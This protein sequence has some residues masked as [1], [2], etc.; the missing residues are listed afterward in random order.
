VIK[1]GDRVKFTE[2][3]GQE[4][5]GEAGEVDHENGYAAIRDDAGDIWNVE[6]IRVDPL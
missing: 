4:H 1:P 2:P 5:V 3:N 6:L